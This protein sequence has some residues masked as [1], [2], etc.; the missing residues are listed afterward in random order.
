MEDVSRSLLIC[1]LKK[2]GYYEMCWFRKKE[3]LCWTWGVLVDWVYTQSRTTS[4]WAIF[5]CLWYNNTLLIERRCPAPI[6][7]LFLMERGYFQVYQFPVHGPPVLQTQKVMV[8]CWSVPV[9]CS[10][11]PS[12]ADT[13]SDGP[14]LKCTSSL[15]TV[16]QCCRHR[17][18]W[19]PPVEVY[20]FPLH[21]PPVLQTQKVMV[22]C[23]S[24][25]VPCSRSPSAADTESDGS[26]LLKCTSSLFMV[27]QCSRH[28]KWW[29]L[30]EVYQ[31]P[32]HGPPV[33]QTQ[34][35]MVPCWSVPVPCSWSPSAADTES[36][37]SPLLKCTSS[38][39]MV[40]QCSRHRKWWSP[41]LR[42]QT[43]Q[44]SCLYITMQVEVYWF[45]IH[46]KGGHFE[47]YQL[48]KGHTPSIAFQHLPPKCPKQLWFYLSW[49]KL[50]WRL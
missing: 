7:F 6:F 42:T 28:R 43:C 16:P 1:A 44:R 50:C 31:F 45:P 8:P 14:L 4:P 17:K 20:Q 27:P 25:P 48:R 22:P 33:Q 3:G 49:C 10:R 37:G 46:E 15:F 21:G 32:V 19:F 47:A 18:W 23:W 34:K 40:P 5:T 41:L 29:S 2:I 36:D 35:V 9:P 13:E 11:S 39:F 24:V 26:P 12:A 30:V 38:L